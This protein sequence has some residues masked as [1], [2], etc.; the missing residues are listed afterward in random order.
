[1]KINFNENNRDD[2]GNWAGMERGNFAQMTK[3]RKQKLPQIQATIQD[4][5]KDYDGQSIAII[6]QHEDENGMPESSTC[7][8]A[9]V[10]RMECQIA[11]GKALSE[12][13]DKAMEVLMESAKGDVKAMLS[14][15]AAL[16]EVIDK[17]K[18]GG[19]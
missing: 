16:V 3:M 12:A 2:S 19:K 7:V 9:G 6:I 8:M 10:S 18:K 4:A 13:S 5:L 17:E 15:A 11:M 14:I 1:M